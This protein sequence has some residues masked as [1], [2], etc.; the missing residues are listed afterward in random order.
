MTDEELRLAREWADGK[1][2]GE[3]W[4]DLLAKA[5][6]EVEDLRRHVQT[7]SD[8]IEEMNEWET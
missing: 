1:W 6:D 3:G 4:M 2:L 5:L 8:E 7:L